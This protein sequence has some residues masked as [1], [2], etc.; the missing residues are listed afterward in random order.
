MCTTSRT[1]PLRARAKTTT[2]DGEAGAA[3]DEDEDDYVDEGD[4]RFNSSPS[5]LNIIPHFESS[6]STFN[7][8][9]PL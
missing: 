3:A 9:P 8:L 2:D 6:S 7:L 4:V 1:A 5:T